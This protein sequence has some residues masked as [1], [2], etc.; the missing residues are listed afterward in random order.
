MRVA[1]KVEGPFLHP[2]P[3]HVVELYS[4]HARLRKLGPQLTSPEDI[5]SVYALLVSGVSL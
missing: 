3:T 2:A 5:P 4:R 1:K